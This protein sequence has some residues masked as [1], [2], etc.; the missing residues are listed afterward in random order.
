MS[1]LNNSLNT[2]KGQLT[3]LAQEILEETAGPG[4][5]EYRN[6]TPVV[7]S[8]TAIDL[9]ADTQ[10][11]KE[12]LDRLCSEKDIEVRCHGEDENFLFCVMHEV[13]QNEK[14]YTFNC[15][16]TSSIDRKFDFLQFVF[17]KLHIFTNTSLFWKENV[18]KGCGVVIFRIEVYKL[19]S[20]SIITPSDS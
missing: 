17:V 2:I 8:R 10:K 9:L 4:D 7:D 13:T 3:T 15:A 18:R 20:K 19:F 12:D 16:A 1:W 14:K 5:A 11:D 6:A